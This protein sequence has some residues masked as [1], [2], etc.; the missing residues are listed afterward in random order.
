MKNIIITF[1]K[2]NPRYIAAAK[3]QKQSLIAKSYTGEYVC[4][5]SENQLG[6]PMHQDNPYA[7]KAYAIKKAFD[8]GYDNILW[9]DSVVQCVAPLDKLFEHIEQTGFAFFDNYTYTIGSFCND[10]CKAIYGITETEL[11]A[12]MIMACVMGLNRDK[13]KDFIAQYYE[14]ALNGSFVGSWDDH[15]HDQ[16]V[17]SLLINR[18]N[19][20]ILQGHETF[21]M[22]ESCTGVQFEYN[23][24]SFKLDRGADVCLLSI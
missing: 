17:A 22:Y 9:L 16:T 18:N 8:E 4:Y 7:F 15:R 12:P 3:V 19:L 21:F 10:S 20:P 14:G 5:T 1:A 24:Q 2:G 13:A 11:Q 6:S 23:N